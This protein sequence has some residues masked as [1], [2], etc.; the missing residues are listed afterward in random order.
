MSGF[1]VDIEGRH[2]E[3]VLVT[4]SDIHRGMEGTQIQVCLKFH[5]Q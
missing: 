3:M 4:T 5:K 2:A 1:P